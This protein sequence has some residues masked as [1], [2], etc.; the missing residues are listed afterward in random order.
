MK[1]NLTKLANGLS[2]EDVIQIVDKLG[3]HYYVET[4][5]AIIFK[6]ICHNCSE[7]EAS[8]KLYYYK[9]NKKFHCYT[10][11]GENFNIFGLFE[12]R[13]KTL[14]VEYNFYSDIILKIMD[15]AKIDTVFETSER[16]VSELSK[17]EQQIV[18]VDIPELNEGI[19]NL[20]PQTYHSDWY[21][22]GISEQAMR[23]FGIRYCPYRRRI[24]IPHY[25]D[26]NKLI[27]I[28]GRAIRE[29][30]VS[31]GKYMPI[32]IEN[33]IYA[34]PLGYN[35]Y[36]LN[37]NKNNIRTYRTAVI[38]EGE[39]S[40]LLYET[41]FGRDKNI[42]VAAC[43]SSISHYQIHLLMKYGA[44][45]IVVAFDNIEDLDNDE[46]RFQQHERLKNLCSR[47]K[48]EVRMG[49]IMD[50]KHLLGSKD[51]PIDCG[52]DIYKQLYKNIEWLR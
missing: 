47:F 23:T 32:T 40:C 50:F 39:K 38:F 27:G 26:E 3:C 49:F 15:Y 24:I 2:N 29:D 36:G 42:S 25:N 8:P 10:E 12:R 5:D 46:Q 14:G 30:N 35:L 48:Y 43:G 44:E 51:S 19:L 13:Y 21:N 52:I 22:D 16:Y 11:C 6:T 28:R 34:H 18:E 41:Y 20:F 17:Y 37:L 1:I 33:K 9:A 31:S 4:Q 7:E 45:Q